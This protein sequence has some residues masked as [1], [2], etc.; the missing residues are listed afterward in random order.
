MHVTV[1]TDLY[2]VGNHST[3]KFS[4]ILDKNVYAFLFVT[5]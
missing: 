2:V 4:N 1:F 5:A 3:Y